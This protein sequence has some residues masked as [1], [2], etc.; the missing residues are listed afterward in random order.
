MSRQVGRLTLAVAL[1]T[2]GV[3]FMVDNLY[4]THV[5]WYVGRLWPALLVVLGLEWVVAS[6]RF[7][8]ARPD[9]GAVVL[10]IVLAIVAAAVGADWRAPWQRHEGRELRVDL[11]RILIPTIPGFGDVQGNIVL[12][13][14]DPAPSMKEL[15]LRN[16]SGDVVVEQGDQLQVQLQVIAWGRDQ[17]D[18][19][20]QARQV[21]LKVDPGAT[22]R[23]S[24]VI[25][26]GMNRIG[27]SWR[28]QVPKGSS[29]K[30]DS[31]S[32]PVTVTGIAADVNVQ[33]S[34]G[35]TTIG[36][37]GGNATVTSS[38]G[39]VK[40][41]RVG[42]SVRATVTSGMLTVEDAGGSV[43]AQTSSGGL[44]VSA[45]KVGGDYDL[46]AVSGSLTVRIPPSAGVTVTARATSGTVFGPDWLTIGEG[47]NSGSGT[48]GGGEYRLGMRT[49]SGSIRIDNR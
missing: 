26:S 11:P 40:I 9:G 41:S 4:G 15:D 30:V 7:A 5:A 18:A 46:A 42:G 17:Q 27:L 20:E 43:T 6:Q 36:N 3:V 37:V 25:P 22:T 33:N 31:S 48:Q 19:E 44:E 21:Q 45:S 13:H 49:S 39:T 23:V 47:R 38:S 34:S 14:A 1:I 2:A 10:L 12:N 35:P 16:M 8:D 28:V 32:G 29:V 24:A